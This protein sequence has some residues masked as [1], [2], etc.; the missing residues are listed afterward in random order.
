MSE[1]KPAIFRRTAPAVALVAVAALGVSACGGSSKGNGVTSK[2][3]D[4]IL[5]TAVGAGEA[6]KS[7][8]VDGAIKD[9]GSSVGLNMSIVA[10]KG[11]SGTVSEGDASFKL[12]TV[13][14]NFYMQPDQ[15]FL[16]KFAKSQAAAQLFKG[17]WLKGSSSDASF[18]SFGELT[19]IKSLM[20][21]LTQSPGTLTKGKTSTLGGQ[22]VIALNSSKGGTM[23]VATTGK[24]YPLQISKNSGTQTGTVTFSQ[25]NKSF[26]ISPPSSSINIEQLEKAG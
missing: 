2:S 24:P 22:K 1:I 9:S 19:S 3:P 20:G 26:A 17:R 21:S 7:L 23:Y 11:A 14:G 5:N 12:I 16:L 13:G 18:A 15:A 10:G 4:Q 8:H 6:A 25:Y